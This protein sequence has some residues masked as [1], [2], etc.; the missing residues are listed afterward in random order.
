M[1][2]VPYWPFNDDFSYSVTSD[3]TGGPLDQAAR[4]SPDV[5]PEI[6]RRRTTARVEM[7]QLG[8]I[9][10]TFDQFNTFEAWYDRD[11]ASGTLPFAWRHPSSKEVKSFRMTGP[12]SVGYPGGQWVRVSFSA[13]ILPGVPFCAPYM[14]ANSARAPD[15]IADYATGQFWNGQAQVTAAALRAAVSGGFDVLEQRADTQVWRYQTY[16]N[17]LPLTAPSGVTWLAGFK[18]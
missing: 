11:I 5:G 3:S 16:S 14:T 7:W 1:Q 8:V 15:W 2:T 17:D 13:M 18:A 10:P 6:V 4:F 9:F 12:Y